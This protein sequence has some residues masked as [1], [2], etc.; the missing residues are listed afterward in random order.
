MPPV[1]GLVIG[2][3]EE[4]S[5]QEGLPEAEVPEARH[6]AQPLRRKAV[7]PREKQWSL[8]S[9]RDANHAEHGYTPVAAGWGAEVAAGKGR[10]RG[11]ALEE[12]L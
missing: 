2:P 12:L 7:G 8:A 11:T 3:G 10:R 9:N 4:K 1:T 5:Y 6:G